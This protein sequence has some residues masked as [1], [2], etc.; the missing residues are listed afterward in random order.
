MQ[1]ALIGVIGGSGLYHM[2]AL[3]NG[4][5]HVFDT[6]Y[7]KPS[8]AIVTGLVHDIPV[9]FLARHGR[10]HRLIPSEIPYRA[11]IYALKQLGVRY[12]ISMSAVGSL[13]EELKP[14]DMVLPDQFIDLTRRRDSTFFGNGA[15]AHIS[16]AQPVCASITDALA[17]AVNEI[18]L[19]QSIT[20]HRHGTYVC[21]E[22]P[23]FST[24]AESHWYR[25]MGA[26]V[27]GMS[28]MP[29]A[30]LA[31]EAQ[32]AYAT[33]A[34]VTDFDCWH[35]REA[36]VT[37]EMAITNLMKNTERAQQ[38]AA[39][40]IRI[41]GTERPSSIAHDALASAL[42]TPLEEMMAETHERLYKIIM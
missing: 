39:A 37:A 23:Q 30:K 3:Q 17:R 9:A 36:Y 33:L 24:Q 10:G 18:N 1:Q 12:L 34:M 2:P 4:T 41:I 32:I 22:G 15:V 16:M 8:D 27:I 29:E 38:I 19:T 11:N 7:G 40:A 5:E 20:L 31:R 21:I 28:N 26:S 35:P 14:L 42:I 6:P 13:Q 25:S